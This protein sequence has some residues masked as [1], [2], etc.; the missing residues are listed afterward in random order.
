MLKNLVKNRNLN[1]KKFYHWLLHGAAWV[2]KNRNVIAVF[3]G[4][5]IFIGII[6][7]ARPA[8]QNLDEWKAVQDLS[9]SPEVSSIVEFSHRGFKATGLS[10][11]I[12]KT[13]KK[14]P[15]VETF[16][17]SKFWLSNHRGKAK[18]ITTKLK[19]IGEEITIDMSKFNNKYLSCI[20]EHVDDY[21]ENYIA[22][23]GEQMVLTDVF[24]PTTYEQ[25]Y[26]RII[27]TACNGNMDLMKFNLLL[28][29]LLHGKTF[30]DAQVQDSTDTTAYAAL[31]FMSVRQI[32][33]EGRN[34]Y[35][36]N[37]PEEDWNRLWQHHGEFRENYAPANAE[38]D[39][40]I[41][42]DLNGQEIRDYFNKCWKTAKFLSN[43][44][45][46]SDS[47]QI[48]FGTPAMGTDGMYH[49]TF[50][51]S[52]KDDISKQYLQ[53]VKIKQTGP[54]SLKFTNV[55][56]KMDI[57][58]S[59]IDD[60]KDGSSALQGFTFVID[61]SSGLDEKIAPVGLCGFKT[62]SV[63]PSNLSAS[64][65][66][67]QLRFA[68]YQG[69]LKLRVGNPSSS[70]STPP[71]DIPH[72]VTVTRYRHTETFEATYNVN[73]HKYDSE[74]GQPLEGSEFDIL[75]AF[76]DS[77]LNSTALES[78]DNWQN[79]SGTQFARW[80]GWDYGKGNPEGDA[81]NDPCDAD[82][83]KTDSD[84]ILINTGTKKPAHTD[85]KTY[86][87][88]KGY[89]GGHP[90]PESEEGEGGEG[91]DD[92]DDEA[93]EKWQE[94]VDKC[95]RLAGEGG[96]FHSETE[97]E[98]QKMLEKDRDEYYKAFISLEYD[99][100]AVEVKAKEGYILH[101]LHTDDIPIES[102]KV[103]SS[104][105]KDLN[106]K[107]G[108]IPH[109]P[110]S[111]SG[112]GDS[113][114]ETANVLTE[115]KYAESSADFIDQTASK[116]EAEA[117]EIEI[118][119][120]AKLEAAIQ[121]AGA[122]ATDS[123]P[124]D[125]ETEVITDLEIL[126][127]DEGAQV[128]TGSEADDEKLS[129]L[130]GLFVEGREISS[131]I[132]ETRSNET[133]T[134]ASDDEDEEH[135]SGG[136]GHPERD[137]TS[138]APSQADQTGGL[139]TTI[140]DHT[141]IIFNHRTEGEIHFNKQDSSLNRKN[142]TTFDS[143]GMENAD[144]SLE[145]AVYG[146]FAA[147]DILHPDGHTKT[148][149]Q[150]DDLVAIATTDRNGDASFM[151]FTEAPGR[152]YDYAQGKVIPRDTGWTGPKN[153]HQAKEKGDHHAQDNETYIGLDSN[154]HPQSLTDSKEGDAMVYYKHSSNQNG[155]MGI[156]G[157]FATYPISNNE[158][159]NGN[160]WIGRPL[161]AKGKNQADYYVKELS[162][163]EGYELS[164]YGRNNLITNMKDSLDQIPAFAKVT[165]TKPSYDLLKVAFYSTLTAENVNGDLR[166]TANGYTEGASFAIAKEQDVVTEDMVP[167]STKVETPII[168]T[169]GDFVY[170]N[171]KRIPAKVG[172]TV[173]VN[174]I[175]YTV[176]TVSSDGIPL[177][178]VQP[179][180]TSTLGTPK[181]PSYGSTDYEDFKNLYNA[182][183][184]SI[185]Y[186]VPT[187]EAPWI[188]VALQGVDETDWIINITKALS[189]KGLIYYNAIEI[190]D[191]LNIDGKV[192]AVIAYGQYTKG[193][194]ADSGIYNPDTNTLYVKK[195]TGKGYFVYVPYSI[196]DAAVSDVQKDTAG[197]VISASVRDQAV[198]CNTVYPGEL[199]D[200]FTMADREPV[201][202]WAYDGKQQKFNNDGSLAVK[203]EWVTE[204]EKI[205]ITKRVEN[206]TPLVSE[207]ADGKY[208]I[209]IPASFIN[210]G[211]SI[212]LK[213]YGGKDFDLFANANGSF[214]Y[215]SSNTKEDSYVLFVTLD[216]PGQDKIWEDGGTTKAPGNVLERPI[217]QKIKVNKDI[218]T[219]PEAKQLWYCLN[220][221]YENGAVT[222]V[223]GHCG[224]TRTTE[225]T[226]IMQYSHDTYSAV[227]SENISANRNHGWYDT[228]KDWLAKLLGG[229][230]TDETA[231]N[232][233]N[234]RFKLYL[235]SNLERLYR[236]NNGNI[237]WLDRNGNEMTPQY[238]DT[239][240][241][242]NYDTFSCT[243]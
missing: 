102:K 153:L 141:F 197:F 192:Y 76:D 147:N 104:E 130:D 83:D 36:G 212:K 238:Q 185:G 190:R 162:R 132:K 110:A 40:T 178:G 3:L 61:P 175:P 121:Y 155:P 208:T 120:E 53:Q 33:G 179:Q 159:H 201:T 26:P 7:F 59:N 45:F 86:I 124:V 158:D 117:E 91:E 227:H 166:I 4:V 181:R 112:G 8:W 48:P 24:M 31:M 187:K 2:N 207:Y 39:P 9:F 5:S 94:E 127:G 194:K 62:I 239:N 64:R 214:L 20:A 129:I 140:V 103:T 63:V 118:I 100:S 65:A 218:R 34:G 223:C 174:G 92:G 209:T 184:R 19:G 231:K 131:G 32:D 66:T 219:F 21:P 135:S 6:A 60:L 243:R 196:H 165:I 203:T 211:E 12:T 101:G 168:G 28:I 215:D 160:C 170:L 139:D 68:A 30:T 145:G 77:Q 137:A 125:T 116:S 84:G 88:E 14:P 96:F 74:T 47:V 150:K 189:D 240:N 56:S 222:G 81:G 75:E 16:S 69:E 37:S 109:K 29:S 50:D 241:D 38:N 49:I 122:K 237:L 230:S 149:Y 22:V 221:G 148:V 58:S 226:K 225:E 202:Y 97:G 10:F 46:T 43:F 156:D 191:I 44:T 199:P 111:P 42:N 229:E 13:Y 51:Y 71:V 236:D 73:L 188:R 41:W 169:E 67:G 15:A 143:Y 177:I 108:V 70:T 27:T 154:N 157:S 106:S 72:D 142:S 18:T 173:Q 182:E 138:F 216:Y 242:G 213:V 133:D 200:S 144:G 87:Y 234:F 193:A 206:M 186:K 78:L 183:L 99:Y 90:L 107:G 85:V 152:T 57:A 105:L 164:V 232:I 172:D 167:V 126:T 163:S 113:S 93:M 205:E 220:C 1:K 11:E 217:R 119:T 128:A 161:I 115:N 198:A 180:N 35:A 82:L 79:E 17:F 204:Y 114:E 235:K 80:D 55:D 89:C 54:S 228:A 52:T 151:A 195:D 98:A 134:F 25:D 210:D 233:P 171:H 95:V 136:G 123:E 23:F 146:L 176:Q 224:N